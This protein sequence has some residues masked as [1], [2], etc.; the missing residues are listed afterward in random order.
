MDWRRPFQ[1]GS[2]D[3]ASAHAFGAV[4]TTFVDG[5]AALL[6]K[7]E[8]WRDHGGRFRFG[9]NAE[10]AHVCPLK[11]MPVILTTPE[12]HDASLRAPRD[13]LRHCSVRCRTALL[14]S[15]SQSR[16]RRQLSQR[17]AQAG[18]TGGRA[19]G[20]AIRNPCFVLAAKRTT[21]RQIDARRRGDL[22]IIFRGVH[23][24]ITF[25]AQYSDSSE[26]NWSDRICS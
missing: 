18:G 13:E 16:T 2:F 1:A 24:Q 20:R 22:L 10:V 11:A 5:R 23:A 7:G 19:T 6:A 4:A 3:K 12:Q 9:S 8:G 17:F 14:R 25:Q 26:R 15:S 21:R